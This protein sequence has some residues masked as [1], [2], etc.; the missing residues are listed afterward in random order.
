[1]YWTLWSDGIFE[2]LFSIQKR[3]KN[4]PENPFHTMTSQVK[5]VNLFL[6]KK[7]L[8]EVEMKVLSTF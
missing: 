1:M 7:Y 2:N 5:L 4:K 6:V 3:K 8:N